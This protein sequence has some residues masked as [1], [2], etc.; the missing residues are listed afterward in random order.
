VDRPLL[1]TEG[2]SIKAI[3]ANGT[4]E[5]LLEILLLILIRSFQKKSKFLQMWKM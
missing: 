4:V 3:I 5:T 1:E 2:G